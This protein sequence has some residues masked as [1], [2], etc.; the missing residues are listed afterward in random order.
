MALNDD[1]L[2]NFWKWFTESEHLIQGAIQE[3]S[4]DRQVQ[5]KEQLDNLVLDFGMLTWDLGLDDNS[6][7]FFTLSP[8]GD[9]DLLQITEQI[10]AEAPTH[11]NWTFHASRPAKDW[12]R[13]FRIYDHEMEIQEVDASTWHYVAFLDSNNKIE[14]VIEVG[15]L[16]LEEEILENA[17]NLFLTNEIGERLLI[18]DISGIQIVNE[19]EPEDAAVKYPIADLKSHLEG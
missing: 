19:M 14:L 3:E 11:L 12:D 2:E 10:I 6:N 13:T 15:D 7:W 9:S 5:I 4:V 8:N 18:T 1:K 17:V 16:Q